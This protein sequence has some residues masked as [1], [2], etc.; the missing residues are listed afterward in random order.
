MNYSHSL[1]I[2]I[3]QTLLKRNTYFIRLPWISEHQVAPRKDL[4]LTQPKTLHAFLT[5][6]RTLN[7]N[8]ASDMLSKKGKIL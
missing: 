8:I 4:L 2:F 6:V 5:I 3:F 1:V 7:M